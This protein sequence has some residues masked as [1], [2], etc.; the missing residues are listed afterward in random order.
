MQ[1][2]FH[3]HI[4]R[5]IP[6]QYKDWTSPRSAA[7]SVQHWYLLSDCRYESNQE[8]RGNT[9]LGT[10]GTCR[11]LTAGTHYYV[12]SYTTLSQAWNHCLFDCQHGTSTDVI[13]WTYHI[14]SSWIED[15]GVVI[16]AVDF[17]FTKMHREV[18]K[19]TL[20]ETLYFF[21]LNNF[22]M[23]LNHVYCIWIISECIVCCS[24]ILRRYYL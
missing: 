9:I 11:K 6:L 10:T 18:I 4:T 23:D 24:S 8:G 3:Q 21:V 20:F 15:C 22:V 7:V 12:R 1:L 14:M 16:G 17:L 13:S 2:Q 5:P 19:R